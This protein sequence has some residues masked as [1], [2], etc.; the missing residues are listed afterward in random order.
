MSS[1]LIGCDMT[2]VYNNA[3]YCRG[4]ANETG[5]TMTGQAMDTSENNI[6]SSFSLTY[7]VATDG[8]YV[9]TLSS[10]ATALMDEGTTYMVEVTVLLSGHQVDK[11]RLKETAKYHGYTP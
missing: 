7:D 3:R 6:G 1:F 4:G 8:D 11:R 2:V 10:D 5:L 9:G